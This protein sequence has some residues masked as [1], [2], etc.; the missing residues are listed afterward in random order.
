MIRAPTYSIWQLLT[1]FSNPAK[2]SCLQVIDKMYIS[3]FRFKLLEATDDTVVF[4]TNGPADIYQNAMLI[5]HCYHSLTKRPYVL[6]FNDETDE[7]L[8]DIVE[9]AVAN[10][11]EEFPSV[12]DSVIKQIFYDGAFRDPRVR[13]VNV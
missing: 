11:P 2:R 3:A 13:W 5:T 12:A 1:Q 7:E 10:Y 4:Y 9:K 8:M 6:L